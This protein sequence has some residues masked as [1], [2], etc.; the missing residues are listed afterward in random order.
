[1][2]L[3]S[4]VTILCGTAAVSAGGRA[5]GAS[6]FVM[7]SKLAVNDTPRPIQQKD[8]AVEETFGTVPSV[9]GGAGPFKSSAVAKFAT[10]ITILK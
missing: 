7:K 4:I 1:M 5:T 9:R 3:L 8:V 10:I 6:T 2:R